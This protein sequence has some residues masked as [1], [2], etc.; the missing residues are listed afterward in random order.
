MRSHAFKGRAKVSA[1]LTAACGVLLVSASPS[2]A[3]VPHPTHPP[4]PIVPLTPPPFRN[5]HPTHPVA[6]PTPVPPHA[7]GGSCPGVPVACPQQA[8]CRAGAKVSK[9]FYAYPGRD[10]NL[11]ASGFFTVGGGS[12]GIK[13]VSEGGSLSLSD[14]GGNVILGMP[15]LQFTQSG[16]SFVASNEQGVVQISPLLRG[17]AFSFTFDNPQFA[18]GFFAVRYDLCLN[19]GDDG[20]W[21]SVVCQKKPGGGFICHQ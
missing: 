6:N 15:Q 9:L 10:R 20:M 16:A 1:L 18:P 17:F 7:G 2:F 4:R 11:R 19:I 5:P 21:D 8:P 14:D 3:R 13:P 12:N